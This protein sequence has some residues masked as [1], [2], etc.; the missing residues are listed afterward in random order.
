MRVLVL[1]ATGYVGSRLVPELVDQG[2]EV[3]AASS[4]DP[5]P[6]RWGFPESVSWLRCD[7]TQREDVARAFADVDTVC[8]LVHS[9]SSREFGER[10]LH[11]A[12]VVREA[13]EGSPVQRVVYLSGLVPPIDSGSLSE[14]LAS[15]LAVEEQLMRADCSVAV[16]RAGMLIGA[17]STSFEI[18][19]QLASLLWLQP[20]PSWLAASRMQPI[21]ISDCIRALVEALA[22]TSDIEGSIDIGSPDQVSYPELMGLFADTAGI[23]RIRLSVPFVPERLAALATAGLVQAPFW[24]VVALVESLRTDMV[25]RPGRTWKPADGSPLLGVREALRRAVEAR[26]GSMEGPLPSDPEWV[27]TRAPLLDELKAPLNLRAGVS[28]GLYRWRQLMRQTTR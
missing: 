28:L 11:G 18:M 13:I 23:P 5:D 12:R 8:Y 20:I 6:A 9:L 19:R 21:A 26:P 24:T 3:V 1:G 17:G 25:C 4:S 16:L 27:R 2:H 15:R 22:P 10:D 14:H 7:V